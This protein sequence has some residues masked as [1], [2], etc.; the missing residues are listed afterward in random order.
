MGQNSFEDRH[1]ADYLFDR[2]EW[3]GTCR[4]CGFKVSDTARRQAASQFRAHIRDEAEAGKE[5]E[6]VID[7]RGPAMTT[8]ADQR[9]GNVTSSVDHLSRPSKESI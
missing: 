8:A 9:S 1:R 2:G 3:R 7:V 4:L 5:V 6:L